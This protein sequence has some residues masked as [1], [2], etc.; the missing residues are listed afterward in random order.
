M[1]CF[2]E[3]FTTGTN[4]KKCSEFYFVC[5]D[6]HTNVLSAGWLPDSWA[7]FLTLR[8]KSV[9]FTTGNFHRGKAPGEICVQMSMFS[10]FQCREGLGGPYTSC[11]LPSI[12]QLRSPQTSLR[13]HS[14][15]S[16]T[17]AESASP[18]PLLF[19][20]LRGQ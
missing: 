5:P 1:S 8:L 20:R 14:H 19:H 11:R 9:W 15:C 16:W 18:S 2:L 4:L 12:V 6:F 10:V 3:K 17:E 13:G 7:T